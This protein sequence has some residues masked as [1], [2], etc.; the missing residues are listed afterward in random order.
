ML[1]SVSAALVWAEAISWLGFYRK[2]QAIW[3]WLVICFFYD[4]PLI[5]SDKFCVCFIAY[6]IMCQVWAWKNIISL[7]SPQ[8]N[9]L[10]RPHCVIKQLW[11]QDIQ[12]SKCQSAGCQK[13]PSSNIITT[14]QL[15]ST[16]SQFIGQCVIF[17]CWKHVSATGRWR[18]ALTTSFNDWSNTEEASPFVEQEF[19]FQLIRMFYNEWHWKCFNVLLSGCSRYQKSKQ[20]GIATICSHTVPFITTSMALYMYKIT[21]KTICKQMHSNNWFT[22]IDMQTYNCFYPIMA[23]WKNVPVPT[24]FENSSSF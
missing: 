8:L 24:Y 5:L 7:L 4:H 23:H 13:K 12:N 6:L 1:T 10:L 18:H 17:L 16:M 2:L 20:K 15:I 3:I 19:S 9:I 21:K 14:Q 11:E 22:S